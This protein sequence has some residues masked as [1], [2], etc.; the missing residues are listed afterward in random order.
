M[1]LLKS[2]LFQPHKWDWGGVDGDDCT[3]FCASWVLFAAGVDLAEDL[4][5]TYTDKDGANAVLDRAGGLE[6]FL[7]GRLE[8]AGFPPTRRPQDG[9]I[10]IV[11]GLVSDGPKLIPAIRF[12]PLWAVMTARGVAIKH[13]EWVGVAWRVLS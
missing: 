11:R 7:S 1:Q 9:D 6:A 2:F 12:G 8:P 5:G 3:T 10:G 4:R 13:V